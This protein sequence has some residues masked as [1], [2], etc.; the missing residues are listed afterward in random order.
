MSE[1]VFDS[2]RAPVRRITTPDIQIPFSPALEK[3]LY[4]NRIAIADAV[5][6]SLGVIAPEAAG[7]N[8]AAGNGGRG[9]SVATPGADRE[10]L[11]TGSA[12]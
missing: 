4:P 10:E 11:A 7:A 2:L 8:G 5:R 9:G 3:Q 6:A 12:R 1:H